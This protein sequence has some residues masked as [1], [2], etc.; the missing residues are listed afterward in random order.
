[1]QLMETRLLSSIFHH[2]HLVTLSGGVSRVCVCLCTRSHP[3]VSA[4]E[5]RSG[6]STY[7]LTF[8]RVCRQPG[9]FRGRVDGALSHMG[10]PLFTPWTARGVTVSYGWT[11]CTTSAHQ[12]VVRL[13]LNAACFESVVFAKESLTLTIEHP[14]GIYY[15]PLIS[16]CYTWLIQY[17][18][19]YELC[20]NFLQRGVLLLLKVFELMV[21][22]WQTIKL[23]EGTESNL[24]SIMIETL[25]KII[26]DLFCFHAFYLWVIFLQ[27]H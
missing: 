12:S 17:Y 9:F 4:G 18:L 22:M 3:Y 16:K 5:L 27:T 10:S 23:K 14:L 15:K 26:F 13:D 8:C 7:F 24:K 20:N 19:C 21:S 11:H 2:W 6:G 25:L 1:M